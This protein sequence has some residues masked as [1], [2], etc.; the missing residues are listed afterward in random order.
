MSGSLRQIITEVSQTANQIEALSHELTTNAEQMNKASGYIA[1]AAEQVSVGA[2]VQ[3]RDVEGTSAAIHHM[4]EGLAA[5]AQSSQQVSMNSMNALEKVFTGTESI[6]L[7][8]RQ[9]NSIQEHVNVLSDVV[10]GL[11]S[12]SQKIDQIVGAITEISSQ[13]NLLALNAAIEAARAGEHGHGFSIVAM[14]V[15]KLAEQSAQAAQQ[16]AQLITMIQADTLQTVDSVESVTSEV[17]LGIQVMS[18][19]GEAFEQIRYAVEEITHQTEQVS[20][21][22]TATTTGVSHVVQAIHNISKVAEETAQGTRRVSATTEEQ[23]ISM[24]EINSSANAMLQM[25]EELNLLIKRFKT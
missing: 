7:A 11:G 1:A 3:V 4:S 15:R 6:K 19:A 10:T 5:V 20:A 22:S 13:T 17:T 9:M 2:E 8:E 14:E 21:A 18:S 16:I 23:L 25:S 12:R 24:E